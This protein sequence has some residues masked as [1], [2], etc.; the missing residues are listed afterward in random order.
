MF[1]HR[2]GPL[3]V[4]AVIACALM[5]GAPA[6]L[7]AATLLWVGDVD[8]AWNTNSA[9]NANWSADALPAAS[10]DALTVGSAGTSGTTLNNDIVGLSVASLTFNAGAAAFTL[11][12]LSLIH[13]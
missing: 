10:G 6:P 12:G 3:Q 5:C 11:T 13:I 7:R 4:L 9:G 8:A 1:C 2:Q